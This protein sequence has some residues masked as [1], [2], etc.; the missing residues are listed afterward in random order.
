MEL[1]RPLLTPEVWEKA[2]WT[3]PVEVTA[4][5]VTTGAERTLAVEHWLLTAAADVAQ[6]RSAWKEGALTLLR[7]G[8]RFTA[9]RIPGDT[10]RAAAGSSTAGVVDAFLAESLAGGPVIADHGQRSYYALVPRSA[11][12]SRRH[13]GCEALEPGTW[14]AVPPVRRTACTNGEAYWAVPMSEPGLLCH[15]G[16]IAALA[17]PAASFGRADSAQRRV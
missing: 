10:V 1:A 8:A 13:P 12:K 4:S 17:Q 9:V 2:A 7:C 14:I 5:A 3:P 15:P 6:S 11:G 16:L